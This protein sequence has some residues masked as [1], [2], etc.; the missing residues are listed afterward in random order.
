MQHVAQPH[1]RF[2]HKLQATMLHS[3]CPPL[4]VLDLLLNFIMIFI[5]IPMPIGSALKIMATG[6]DAP[7]GDI[8]C[9]PGL[10]LGTSL[11]Y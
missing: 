3:G 9:Q 7:G 6:G 2:N 5:H 8:N 11:Y 4:D 10:Y 1:Q